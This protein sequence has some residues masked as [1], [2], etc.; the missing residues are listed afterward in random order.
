[1]KYLWF[2]PLFWIT[3]WV[4]ADTLRCGRYVVSEGMSPY[5][6]VQKCGEPNF[7]QVVREVVTVVV[8][9]Q[10]RVEAVEPGTQDALSRLNVTTQEQAPLYRDIDRWTYDFGSGRLL[11]E[12]DFYNGALIR[13]RTA[14]RSP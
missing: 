2:L 11:R 12:V 5:E 9:R 1:M 10:S 14:G 13:I 8:N 3:G 4:H 7:Q 6:V